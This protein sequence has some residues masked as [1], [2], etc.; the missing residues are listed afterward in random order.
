MVPY[1]LVVEEVTVTSLWQS[2]ALTEGFR[3]TEQT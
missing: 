1:D 2:P 3:Y